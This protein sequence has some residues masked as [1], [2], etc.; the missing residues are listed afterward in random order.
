[1]LTPT[2][3]VALFFAG[4]TTETAL[5]NLLGGLVLERNNL[6]D[7][8]AAIDVR[9]AWAVTRFASRDLVF[10]TTQSGQTGVR[11]MRVGL[12]LILVARLTGLAADVITGRRLV[13]IARTADCL[14]TL[15][16]R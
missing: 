3:V 7:I 4:V 6:G 2:K 9:L 16:S 1:M 12:E 15:R 13:V 14:R 11:G 8:A 10:P 5:G